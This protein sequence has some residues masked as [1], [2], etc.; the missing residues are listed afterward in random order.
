MRCAF[1]YEMRLCRHPPFPTRAAGQICTS[2]SDCFYF[3]GCFAECVNQ[4]CQCRQ[5]YSAM[6]EP[7]EITYIPDSEAALEVAETVAGLEVAGDFFN[8]YRA[9]HPDAQAIIPQAAVVDWYQQEFTYVGEPAPRAVKV[10]FISWTWEVTG[11][12]FSETAEVVLRQQ[13]PDGTVV[14]DEVCLVEDQYCNSGGL[15]DGTELS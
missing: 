8:L 2:T 14:R 1:T 10:R 12:T 11:Q 15:S 4:R 5:P 13:V 3:P 6:P 7:P 9:M